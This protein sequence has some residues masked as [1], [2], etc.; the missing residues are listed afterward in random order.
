[1][2]T[3]DFCFQPKNSNT[4]TF[5]EKADDTIERERTCAAVCDFQAEMGTVTTRTAKTAVYAP[6]EAVGQGV[7]SV[8]L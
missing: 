4:P 1:M 2:A 3:P 5:P 8:P 7:I 6:C